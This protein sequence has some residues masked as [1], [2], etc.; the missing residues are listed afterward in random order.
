MTSFSDFTH[1]KLFFFFF[2]LPCGSTIAFMSVSCLCV[3]TDFE[4]SGHQLS[5]FSHV[6]LLNTHL[7]FIQTSSRG[8]LP[9]HIN[10]VCWMGICGWSCIETLEYLLFKGL[11]PYA[12]LVKV[13]LGESWRGWCGADTVSLTGRASKSIS[14][15]PLHYLSQS[16]KAQARS[17]RSTAWF[18]CVFQCLCVDLTSS[19]TYI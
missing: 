9:L 19:C 17:H 6:W 18:V 15:L 5:K 16:R 13:V 11:V 10:I 12:V 14:R 7:V 3:H 4:V 2:C 1:I 8:S